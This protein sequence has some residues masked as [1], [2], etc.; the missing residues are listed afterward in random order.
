MPSLKR[1]ERAPQPAIEEAAPSRGGLASWLARWLPLPGVPVA[2]A[3]PAAQ[4]APLLVGPT[5]QAAQG[6]LAGSGQEV[7]VRERAGGDARAA[8]PAM[9]GAQAHAAQ[10]EARESDRGHVLSILAPE[11][12]EDGAVALDGVRGAAGQELTVEEERGVRKRIHSKF[13]AHRV[14]G[15]TGEADVGTAR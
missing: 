14:V 1:E 5:G 9:A 2:P 7:V 3:A 4:A 8:L 6:S 10:A 13:R 12:D 15:G 11:T